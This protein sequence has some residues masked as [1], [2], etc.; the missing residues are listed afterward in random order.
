MTRK[1]H[2]AAGQTVLDDMPLHLGDPIVW[3]RIDG[4]TV[5]ATVSELRPT[6]VLM[7]CRCGTREWTRHQTL[8]LYK[9]MV[10]QPW[11]TAELLETIT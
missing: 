11:T 4:T 5:Y 1:A 2:P 8:P 3:H 10:R 7:R 9:S 6:E